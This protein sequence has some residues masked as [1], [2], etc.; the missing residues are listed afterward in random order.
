MIA[1]V[2]GVG[3]AYGTGHAER[4]RALRDLLAAK[5]EVELILSE[6]PDRERER[7]AAGRA[8]L[9]VLDARDT[10]P[11]FHPRILALDNRFSGRSDSRAAFHDTLPHPEADLDQVMRNCLIRPD[12]LAAARHR[13]DIRKRGG[14]FVYSGEARPPLVAVSPV[15]QAG[16]QRIPGAGGSERMERSAFV[17]SLCES[18]AAVS[19]FGM[20]VLEAMFLGLPAATYSIG[21]SVH[22]SLSLFLEEKAGVPFYGEGKTVGAEVFDSSARLRPTGEGYAV[23]INLI[24]GML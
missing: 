16:R 12:L 3:P 22:D 2:A 6:Q 17:Q 24:E 13:G 8:D 15:V 9:V 5:H 19:Y 1:I 18:A 21:S 23:L 20:T 7:A 4:M 14:L 11:N 10:D